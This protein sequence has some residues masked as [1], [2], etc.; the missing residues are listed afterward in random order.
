MATNSENSNFLAIDFG[1]DILK[2][3]KDK[4]SEDEKQALNSFKKLNIVAFKKTADNEA[5]Y[6]KEK[7]EVQNI[8]KENSTYEQLMRFGSKK[9]GASIY[10]VGK[11]EKFDEFVLFGN[12]NDTGFAIVRI[13]G[14]NM[15]PNHLMSLMSIVQ[16]ADI[17][18]EQIKPL[19]ESFGGKIEE[20]IFI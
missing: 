2:V 9:Q 14:K 8:L 20:E 18:Q 12:Q 17:D 15:T 5:L 4:L 13:I 10:A 7:T 19:I 11:G 3:S 1:A 6:Q 16:K